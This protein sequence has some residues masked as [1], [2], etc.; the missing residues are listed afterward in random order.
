MFSRKFRVTVKDEKINDLTYISK[1]PL[2]F[3]IELIKKLKEERLRELSG[4]KEFL[5]KYRIQCDR[6]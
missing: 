6:M 2:N 5:S 4:N 3:A 1:E